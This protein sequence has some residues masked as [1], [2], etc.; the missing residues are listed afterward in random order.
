VARYQVMNHGDEAAKGTL[1]VEGLASPLR[2]P[3]DCATGSA[4]F[5]TVTTPD[6]PAVPEG[7]LEAAVQ[8]WEKALG[9][10]TIQVPDPELMT[11][12]HLAAAGLAHAGE[13]LAVHARLFKI[14]GDSIRLVPDLP[15][16]WRKET[17]E[18]RALPTP[19]GPLT[20]VYSGAFE[21]VS[22]ELDGACK[23]PTGFVLAVP[24]KSKCKVDGA[25]APPADGLLKVPAAARRLEVFKP[26]E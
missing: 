2:F 17:V 12:Y 19:F 26:L 22:I 18:A 7:A 14:E 1:V 16:S 4:L 25:D 23:P 3:V 15:E 5:F 8:A 20:F 21:N 13:D 24:P 11:R 9:G 10:R 6:L